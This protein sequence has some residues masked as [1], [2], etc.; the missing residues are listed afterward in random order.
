MLDNEVLDVF[1]GEIF[2]WDGGE[3]FDPVG[4]GELCDGDFVR[5]EEPRA[6]YNASERSNESKERIS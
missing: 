2:C 3:I 4:D 6:D 1:Q 5:H